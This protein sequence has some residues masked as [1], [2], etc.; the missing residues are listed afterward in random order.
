MVPQEVIGS[1]FDYMVKISYSKPVLFE[2]VKRPCPVEVC[3]G[4]SSI[5]S[6]SLVIALDSPV[7]ISEAL[8]SAAYANTALDKLGIYHK[9]KLAVL[10]GLFILTQPMLYP[11]PDTLRPTIP[12]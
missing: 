10:N 12:E 3:W 8:I 7:V 4:I 5:Q 9:D 1:Q 6:K 11:P 2:D